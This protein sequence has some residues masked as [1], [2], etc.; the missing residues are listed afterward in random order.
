M[1]GEGFRLVYRENNK[2]FTDEVK[3][4]RKTLGPMG[5]DNM[6]EYA[7]KIGE[8]ARTY[9]SSYEDCRLAMWMSIPAGK[10]QLVDRIYKLGSPY[11]GADRLCG[12]REKSG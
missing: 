6:V 9:S 3:G 10:R 8:L 4:V 2:P 5:V 1:S 11:T 12:W 7:Q